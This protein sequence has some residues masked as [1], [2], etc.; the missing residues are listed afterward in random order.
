MRSA[1]ET[2]PAPTK[3]GLRRRQRFRLRSL[4]K[5]LFERLEATKNV[6][7]ELVLR[8]AIRFVLRQL[9]S[10]FADP[11]ISRI[12]LLAGGH[13]VGERRF[14]CAW[15][16]RLWSSGGRPS[17]VGNG[18]NQVEDAEHTKTENC[19][20]QPLPLPWREGPRKSLAI[21]SRMA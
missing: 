9:L 7:V 18:E 14:L 8:R 11:A 17:F 10:R 16:I 1:A 6:L 4:S 20:G 5:L 13:H 19:D 21:G 12:D 2:N 15:K 3:P